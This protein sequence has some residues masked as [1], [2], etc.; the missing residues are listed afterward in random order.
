MFLP[1]Q[2]EALLAWDE[3]KRASGTLGGFFSAHTPSSIPTKIKPFLTL[4]KECSFTNLQ[5]C[6][7]FEYC[8]Q[9]IWTSTGNQ[10]PDKSPENHVPVF[11]TYLNPGITPGFKQN[12]QIFFSSLLWA[13]ALKSVH[14]S[15]FCQWLSQPFMISAL[16]R[17][18]K[19][20][21]LTWLRNRTT[22]IVTYNSKSI[23]WLL[24]GSGKHLVWYLGPPT[25]YRR[26]TGSK[27][28][29]SPFFTLHCSTEQDWSTSLGLPLLP[30]SWT[31]SCCSHTFAKKEGVAWALTSSCPGTREGGH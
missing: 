18:L 9:R 15:V 30:G 16:D 28:N 11:K 22:V 23:V 26:V 3:G 29:L 4:Q 1:L 12:S 14:T 24:W 13:E 27:Y 6:E 2:R 25:W 7:L 19:T 5:Q 21:S 20:K 10:R 8:S 17:E 31:L